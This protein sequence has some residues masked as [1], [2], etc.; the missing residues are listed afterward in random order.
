METHSNSHIFAWEIPWTE[1]SGSLQPMGSQES[2][3]TQ[4]LNHYH[5]QGMNV[6]THGS[7]LPLD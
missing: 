2:D 4:Q 3:K 6:Y 5:Q 7:W 1:E